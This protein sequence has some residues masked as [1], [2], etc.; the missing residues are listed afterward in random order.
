MRIDIIHKH[1]VTFSGSHNIQNNV[2]DEKDLVRSQALKAPC[3][4]VLN[5]LALRQYFRSGTD[6]IILHGILK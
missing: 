6:H 2:S 3:K 4:K 1:P 5:L